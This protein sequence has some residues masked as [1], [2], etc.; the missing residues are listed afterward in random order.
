[1]A[2]NLKRRA[3]ARPDTVVVLPDDESMRALAE[4]YADLLE[5]KKA[6]EAELSAL[7]AAICSAVEPARDEQLR[8][9]NATTSQSIQMGDDRR[10]LVQ[11]A[12][13]FRGLDEGTTLLD[14][15]GQEAGTLRQA[16]KE[17]FGSRYDMYVE[18]L[19]AVKVKADLRKLIGKGRTEDLIREG[20]IT[21]SVTLRPRKNAFDMLAELYKEGRY[22]LAADLREFIEATGQSPALRVTAC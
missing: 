11:H 12:A 22:E 18:R 15:G 6:A 8:R 20:T 10:L 19:V 4:A 2:L 5:E 13:R 9:G 21:E 1:M 7:K 14:D 16:L 17:R 3:V